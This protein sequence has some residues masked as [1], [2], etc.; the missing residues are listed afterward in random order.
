MRRQ[1]GVSFIIALA[2]MAL[3]VTVVAVYAQNQTV[4]FKAVTARNE[5]RRAEAAAMAGVQRALAELQAVVDAPG[6]PV[7]LEDDWAVLGTNGAEE[8]TMGSDSFR[9]QIIDNAARI[10]LNTVTEA[11]LANL[12][13]TQ[14]Q[15]DSFLDWRNV[16]ESNRVEGAKD[17]YYNGL[18]RP[19]NAHENQL[20]S[21]YEILDIKGFTPQN[22]F[23]PVD[24]TSSTAA[25][26]AV[27][28]IAL[29]EL[30]T[31]QN[32]SAATTAEGD[33]RVN[34][35]NPQLNAQNF[36]QQAQIPLQT[37]QQI[38]A[39][40]AV[41][42]NATYTAL[43]QV[44]NVPG[45]ANNQAVVRS[46]LDRMTVSPGEQLSGKIN[47]NTAP[48]AVLQTI[49]GIS[50]DIATQIVDSRPTGGYTLLSDL[51]SIGSDQA[52]AGAIADSLNVN[53]QCFLIRVLGKSGRTEQGIE[54]LIQIDQGVL[55]VI[56]IE[57]PP[58]A[59]LAAQ[60]LWDEAT[61]Q[62]P[63]LEN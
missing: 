48:E 15:I 61:T 16:G 1:R 53:S 34:V 32:F 14:E 36:S 7:T 8:F 62:T 35:N 17:D 29:I 56:R 3:V 23:Y 43:S 39:Q 46:V 50:Q 58:Y 30:V 22:V 19:Y 20:Q 49:P 40:R 27:S 60:W 54:A 55:K 42:P 25:S 6:Q 31:T 12:N 28:D 10:D 13:L 45:I 21:V 2:A 63:L 24:N 47:V 5:A 57:R 41:Q 9:I 26:S 33:G 52:F 51:L 38:I 11:H 37:A 44:L 18:A 59:D 4:A